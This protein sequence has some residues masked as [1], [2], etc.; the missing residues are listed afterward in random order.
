MFLSTNDDGT[1][2]M[3]KG[4]IGSLFLLPQREESSMKQQV[5]VNA[6]PNFFTLSVPHDGPKAQYQYVMAAGGPCIFVT[7]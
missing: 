4:F 6:A 1:C 2:N 7:A 5:H 3:P